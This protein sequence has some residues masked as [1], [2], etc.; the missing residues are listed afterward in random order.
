VASHKRILIIDDEDDI[1]EVAAL[2]LETS[3]D[4]EVTTADGG[5]AGLT[6]A[7][8]IRPDL[9]L[10]DV[11]MPELDGPST[12]LQLQES[13]A[14]SSIPVIFLTAKVQSADRRKL[15]D[16]GAIGIIAKP[17]DPMRLASEIVAIVGS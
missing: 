7:L 13:E 2:A 3:G 12:Y 17:F 10:L 4:F 14:T 6:S 9:I 5:R 16:L 1:R 15:S 11:M 8:R